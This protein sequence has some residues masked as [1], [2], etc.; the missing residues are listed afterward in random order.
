MVSSQFY[1]NLNAKV[2]TKLDGE[3][4][5]VGEHGLQSERNDNG[6]LFSSLCANNN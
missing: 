6:E 4:G 5:I 1:I 3:D 2:G